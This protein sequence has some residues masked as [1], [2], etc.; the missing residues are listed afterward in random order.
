MSH[1]TSAIRS[2]SLMSFI[3]E[4]IQEQPVDSTNLPI[5][6]IFVGKIFTIFINIQWNSVWIGLSDLNFSYFVLMAIWKLFVR[7]W[8]QLRIEF[9]VLGHS[10]RIMRKLPY[11]C[12][13]QKLVFS[14]SAPWLIFARRSYR[15]D[16]QKNKWRQPFFQQ[17]KCVFV[18][19]INNGSLVF[20]DDGDVHKVL[21]HIHR[22]RQ[23]H[24]WLVFAHLLCS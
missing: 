17:G 20:K 19:N 21:P 12:I 1:K 14:V 18:I 5:L 24:L 11:I 13:L 4:S 8:R 23:Q 3:N 10:Q 7:G 22:V 6:P 2:F 9:Y 16:R 15:A